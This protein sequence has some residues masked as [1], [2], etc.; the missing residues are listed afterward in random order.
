MF[1]TRETYTSILLSLIH[2]LKFVTRAFGPEVTPYEKERIW[3]GCQT[4]VST[5]PQVF[6]ESCR[7]GI[8]QYHID[9]ALELSQK[10]I[11]N[12]KI[13]GNIIEF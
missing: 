6:F 11:D 7:H 2:I 10:M 8:P 1:L 3:V 13:A 5:C 9:K 4:Y 12:P